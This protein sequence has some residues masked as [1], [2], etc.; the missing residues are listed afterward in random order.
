[1]PASARPPVRFIDSKE[2]VMFPDAHLYIHRAEQDARARARAHHI[3]DVT[4]SRRRRSAGLWNVIRNRGE[5]ARGRPH[6]LP[7][8]GALWRRT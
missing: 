5:R 7:G 4:H 2:T 1:M 6:R 8:R 3:S